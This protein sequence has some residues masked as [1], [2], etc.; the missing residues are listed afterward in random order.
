MGLLLPYELQG[1]TRPLSAEAILA[2]VFGSV[3]VIGSCSTCTRERNT[4]VRLVE[5]GKMLSLFYSIYHQRHV[6]QCL[7]VV[8][9]THRSLVSGSPSLRVVSISRS[10]CPIAS[11]LP[12][13]LTCPFSLGKVLSTTLS[14]DGL[15]LT[16]PVYSLPLATSPSTQTKEKPPTGQ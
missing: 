4:K 7:R 9:S 14:P 11:P 8:I 1:G 2:R 16:V 10:G 15:G 13:D 12:Y 3:L 5:L 6:Y